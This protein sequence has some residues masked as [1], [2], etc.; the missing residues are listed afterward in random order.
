MTHNSRLQ[1]HPCV[2]WFTGLS[3]AGKS[4]TAMAVQQAL[5][6]QGCKNYLLDGDVVRVGLCNDLGFSEADRYENIRRIG[7]VAR[8]MVDAGLLVICATISPYRQMRNNLRSRFNGHQFV[9]VFIDSPLSVC[10]ERDVKG[11]YRKARAGEICNFT[12]VDS[13]YEAP[14]NPELHLRTDQLS[15]ADCVAEIL[16]Y[17]QKHGQ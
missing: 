9:E 17:L 12:G 2:L 16:A 6:R 14:L 5:N 10:E 1:Y 11:L 3:G 8:L 13:P 7:E 15:I 4:T